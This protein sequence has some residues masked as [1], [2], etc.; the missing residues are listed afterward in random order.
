MRSASFGIF[1]GEGAIC[2][3]II[4]SGDSLPIGVENPKTPKPQNPKFIKSAGKTIMKKTVLIMGVS[5][6]ALIDRRMPV[7]AS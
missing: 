7:F 2:R 4:I 1:L 5:L 6:L 3:R